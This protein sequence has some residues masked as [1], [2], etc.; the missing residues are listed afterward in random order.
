MFQE[1]LKDYEKLRRNNTMSEKEIIKICRILCGK[2]NK[3]G[4][5][6]YPLFASLQLQEDYSKD[7][8]AEAIEGLLDL[9][10]N[11]KTKIKEII[12]KIDAEDYYCLNEAEE[13]LRKLV[14]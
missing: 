4:K 2:K 11:Q 8:I 12:D 3:K 9:Y 13:D 5:R 7:E 6:E 10:N 14:E 1:W